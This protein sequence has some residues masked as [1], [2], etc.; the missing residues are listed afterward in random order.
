MMTWKK[1]IESADPEMKRG[2]LLRFAAGQPFE[3]HVVMMVCEAPDKSDR[4]GLITISGYKAGI[5]CYVVFP[6]ETS[7]YHVSTRWLIDNWQLWVWPDGDVH[8]VE[9]HEP[10]NALEIE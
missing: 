3:S 7:P 5:N 9:V 1:L 8:E 10:L 4:L 2:T 6:K